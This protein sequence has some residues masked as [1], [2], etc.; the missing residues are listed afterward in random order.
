MQQKKIAVLAVALLAAWI[1][2]GFS[3]STALWGDNVEQFNWAH[4]AQWGYAKHPPVAT[5]ILMGIQSVMGVH[6]SNTH[7]AALICLGLTLLLLHA[8]SKRLLGEPWASAGILLTGLSYAFTS[9]GQLYNHN[10]V[11][12]LAIAAT[13]WLVLRAVDARGAARAVYWSAAGLAAA[14]CVLSKY[15]AVVPLSGVLLALWLSG[16]LRQASTLKGVMV[17][18]LTFLVALA[19]HLA[20]LVRTDFLIF[21][22]A[23]HSVV[24]GGWGDRLHH[25]VSFF[26]QQIRTHWL[27]LAAF[28]TWWWLE[29]R[30]RRGTPAKDDVSLQVEDAPS[31]LVGAWMWGL[32]YF[33]TL[34]F[35]AINQLF[36]VHLQNHWGV[37]L[38]L[39]FPMWLAWRARRAFPKAVT[40]N[41]LSMVLTMHVLGATIF[42]WSS[43]HESAK[44]FEGAGRRHDT[45][46]PAQAM[47]D[48]ALV[49]WAEA[50]NCPLRY[51]EGPAFEAGLISVYSGRYPMVIE[52][53]DMR[54]HPWIDPLDVERSGVLKVSVTGINQPGLKFSIQPPFKSCDP[55]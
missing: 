23:T 35:V 50:T 29:K 6:V 7:W 38:L 9:R 15:Q 44:A 32:L 26:L 19:P 51:V 22:Y 5:W 3:L 2:L 49:H 53:Q 31:K 54:R 36:G 12:I 17:A 8:I 41:L 40:R 16:Q 28:A 13:V 34:A 14:L 20:W 47:A 25:L 21:Q 39:F 37:A 30:R 4:S 52:G 10:V 24:G 55:R 45:R 48:Q 27:M 42:V 1:A 18:A 33:P 43:T 11:L 46:Y